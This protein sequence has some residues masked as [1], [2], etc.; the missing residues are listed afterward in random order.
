MTQ[1]VDITLNPQSIF[2][3]PHGS[4][5]SAY[6]CIYVLNV[7]HKEEI[8]FLR[9]D[10]A[11]MRVR[12][13]EVVRDRDDDYFYPYEKVIPAYSDCHRHIRLNNKLAVGQRMQFVEEILK[14][15]VIYNS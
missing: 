15:L 9:I 3:L 4:H 1:P 13:Q 7:N 12:Q 10:P 2:T 6:G 8:F 11:W 5:V 14:G